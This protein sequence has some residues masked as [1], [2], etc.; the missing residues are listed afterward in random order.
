MTCIQKS[1]KNNTSS[2]GNVL[3][4][5]LIAVALFAALSYAITSSS[6][7]GGNQI[8]DDKAKIVAAQILQILNRTT[9]DLQRFML[10]DGY[11]IE[12]I[13][14][15]SDGNTL[16]GNADSCSTNDCNLFHPEGGNSPPP[17]LPKQAIELGNTACTTYTSTGKIL[18]YPMIVSVQDIGSELSDIILYYCGVEQKVCEHINALTKVKDINDPVILAFAIGAGGTNYQAFS[19]T[20]TNPVF[21]TTANQ[22]GNGE[23]RIHGKYTFCRNAGPAVGGLLV[24]VIHTR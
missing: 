21:S 3:F 19:S 20:Y 7:T 8:S 2:K 17:V 14:L 23:P 16:T 11:R 1:N 9:T 6:R 12:E 13:D 24:H 4:L 22:I 10:I 18:P 5:I 15:F